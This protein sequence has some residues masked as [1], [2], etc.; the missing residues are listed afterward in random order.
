LVAK[1]RDVQLLTPKV[2]KPL[3]EKGRL[4]PQFKV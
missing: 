3:E 1:N 4:P 2:R